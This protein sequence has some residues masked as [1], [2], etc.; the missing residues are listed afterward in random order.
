[1]APKVLIID[2]SALVHHLIR[3]RLA[4]EA[5]EIFD[6]A[7]GVEGLALA[8]EMLPDLILLDVEMPAPDGFE[9]CGQLKANPA[10]VG[11]P[12]VFI[13]G[14]SSTAE[15]IRGLELG[16]V[17]YVTKPFDPAELRARVRASLR[18]KYLLD[19]LNHKAQIDGVT[20]LW[21]RAYLQQRL[22]QEISMARR[23]GHPLGLILGD[24]DHFR[25]VNETYG[26][27]C[28][29]AALRAMA[30]MMV[31]S[32]RREDIICRFEGAGFAILT[33]GVADEGAAVLAERLRSKLKAEPPMVGPGGKRAGV[34]MSF[35]VA[36]LGTTDTQGSFMDAAGGALKGAKQ[37]GGD[38]VVLAADL[39]EA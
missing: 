21:N 13:T 34:T 37:G 15:K 20:G 1:M 29:D 30:A 3:A 24:A 36:V 9:V 39:V 7:N 8:G 35:G 22:E 16:A 33:P 38:R 10:T 32:S 5:V 28:G 6:A 31:E 11:I 4:G 14:V 25:K 26:L 27:H 12:I 23:H 18:T 19:L 17:D 2:D